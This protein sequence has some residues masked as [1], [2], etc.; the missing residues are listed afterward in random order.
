MKITVNEQTQR[1]Y[2]AMNEW[3]SAIGHEI[4]VGKYRFCAIPLSKSINIS[5]VTSGSKVFDIPMTLA[6]SLNTE[7]KESTLIFLNKVGESLSRIIGDQKKF[8]EELAKMKEKAFERL[9]QMPTIENVD[10]DWLLDD[11]S[12]VL[13]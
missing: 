9:G 4:I 1:F 12:D 6:I 2:L 7:S 11:V 8:D 13:N 3:K 10:T 5:E